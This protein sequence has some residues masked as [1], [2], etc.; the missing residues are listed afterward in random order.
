MALQCHVAIAGSS[1]FH[2]GHI[3]TKRRKN[4]PTQM[5]AHI[6]AMQDKKKSMTKKAGAAAKEE[7]LLSIVDMCDDVILDTGATMCM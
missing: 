4:D 1:G 2:Q 7:Q 5:P 6:Q 3:K